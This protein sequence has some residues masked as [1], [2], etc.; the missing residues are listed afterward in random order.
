MSGFQLW[1]S[2]GA[3]LLVGMF[4]NVGL[5]LREFSF[6]AG[7]TALSSL[8]GL[9]PEAQI[10]MFIGLSLLFIVIEKKVLKEKRR[11]IKR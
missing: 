6:A 4:F 2:L 3:M 7:F 9:Q 10:Q 1:F 5:F 11:I 8:L